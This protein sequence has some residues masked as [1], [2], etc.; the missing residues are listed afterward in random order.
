MVHAQ[1]IE[2]EKL[3][4][5]SKRLKRTKIDDGNSFY[6]RSG[7][8]GLSRFRQRF[9]GQGSSNAP[10]RSNNEM[11]SNPKPQRESSG[12]LVLDCGKCGRKHVGECL[13]GSNACF[14]CGKMDHKIRHCPLVA[15]NEGDSRHRAQPYPSSGLSGSGANAPKQNRF[16]ALQTCGEQE[17]SPDMVTGMLKVFQLD[18]YDLLDPSATLSFVTPYVAMTFHM[19]LDV[20][21]ETFFCLYP[22]W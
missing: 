5:R 13:A 15:K 16:Y 21:L 11:V 1:Q 12:I 7:G 10:P 4:E 14:G 3:K 2:E 6:P 22:C 19:L 8:R 18:V 17:G 9:P 20:L